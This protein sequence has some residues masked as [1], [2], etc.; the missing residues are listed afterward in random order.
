MEILQYA[1]FQNA[2]IASVL[3]AISCGITGTYIVARR[4]VFISG[5][6]THASFG[7]LGIGFFLGINP[8]LS[9]LVFAVL[10]GFGIEYISHSGAYRRI[11]EDSV[12]AAVW[13]LG[14]AVGVIFM[15]LTPG[16]APNLSAYLFG[17]I[18]IVGKTDIIW[19]SI[20]TFVL[21]VFFL[22]GKKMIVYTAFDRDF[23]FTQGLP[24]RF[25]EYTMM[26]FIA[27]TIVLS[28]RLA[29]IMLLLSL[30]TIPHTT[31]NMFT[32]NFNKIAIISC[33]L[34]FTGCIAGLF[35]SYFF[36][37]PSGA[38]I[39]LVLLIFFFIA[40]A[41]HDILLVKQR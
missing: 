40:K 10:S 9:S 15:F 36:N 37:I 1:F 35:L 38:F 25:I 19:T 32:S 24:V 5:G 2:I 23:A 26:F 21:L 13:S 7:G 4:I 41:I 16:Y 39:I 3:I 22:L 6:I 27:A 14:M 17:N 33:L 12:I 29:G 8:I 11:R 31:A 18:L 34:G 20:S 28:I 30:L